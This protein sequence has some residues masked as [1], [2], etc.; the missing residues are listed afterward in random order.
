MIA[1]ESQGD[2]VE[3]PVTLQ[4]GRGIM[5]CA[6]SLAAWRELKATNVR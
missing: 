2:G 6:L 3:R 4:V 1:G 5:I